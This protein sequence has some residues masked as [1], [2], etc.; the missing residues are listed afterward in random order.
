[1]K[2]ETIDVQQLF[3]DRRQYQVPFYQRSYVW[4]RADQWEPLWAD[5]LE[6]AD[7]R[8]AGDGTPT[9]H[10]LGAVVLEP[11]Q[12]EGLIGVD[13]RHII[14]GQQRL[15]T[16]QYLL[17]ALA[18]HV[19][20]LE[21][22][23]LEHVVGTCLW[24]ANE[25]TMK[26]PQ[27]E[28]Y[29]I[30]PTFRDRKSYILAMNAATPDELRDRFPGSFTN[31]GTLRKI[32][33]RHPPALEAIWYFH[34]A[35]ETWLRQNA[36]ELSE[37]NLLS[38]ICNAVLSDMGVVSI[39]LDREDDAQVIFETLNGRG[40]ELHAT[41]LIR[42]FIFM[43]ADRENADSAG[44]YETLWVPFEAEFWSINQRRGRIR[45]PRLEWFVQAT[46]QAETGDEVDIGRL[47]GG[48][49][50]YV[51][52]GKSVVSSI[53]QLKTLSEYSLLYKELLAG[54]GKTPLAEFGRA[55]RHWDPSTSYSLAMF[56]ARY[57]L[58]DSEQEKIYTYLMSYFV[59]RAVCGLTNKS[60]SNVFLSILKKLTATSISSD[61]LKQLLS[62]SESNSARWPSDDEFSSAWLNHAIY[63]G[64]LDAPRV[65]SVLEQM[66]NAMRSEKS[67]DV[68]FSESGNLD[69]DHILP[70]SW[71]EHWPLDDGSYATP[72]DVD[73]V[74][75]MRIAGQELDERD[76][77]I[78]D[79]NLAKRTIGNL[80]LI[81]YGVNRSMQN[82]GFAE[83]KKR[84]FQ[85]SNLHVN[86]ELMIAP[87]WN[88]V[89]IRKR[90]ER[91]L[92][93]ALAVWPGP[94]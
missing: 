3:K 58:S 2:S 9:K 81:H 27:V 29:K 15:T 91:L 4:N 35:I 86:R 19:R 74:A 72:T 77:S 17:A 49:K 84:F 67:E 66:E 20:A 5:I 55:M 39:S 45:K 54:E 85:E 93:H 10:F 65:R 42:N 6:K 24:N 23:P 36:D 76:Q 59:R 89:S 60:Y 64:V 68:K 26:V 56:V 14:D 80:T 34:D 46:V 90:S 70:T 16:L 61:S 44:L 51:T 79:R 71:F 43:R 22:H 69:I 11:Q 47:Y 13:T 8:L 63:P 82:K 1:M 37:E 12:S 88:E 32:G 73:R 33:I 52:D 50:K 41:D 53:D 57:G 40:A 30:Y 38:T 31:R 18:M 25:E 87:D 62:A 92:N 83:K 28:K 7:A 48:Y 78:A 21:G 94:D 75:G